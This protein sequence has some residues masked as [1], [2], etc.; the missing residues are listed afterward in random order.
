MGKGDYQMKIKVFTAVLLALVLAGCSA[1][2]TTKDSGTSSQSTSSSQSQSSEAKQATT[3]DIL[4]VKVTVNEAITTYQKTFAQ[5]DI[6]S[7]SLEKVGNQFQY[8]VEGVDDQREHQLT[9]NATTSSVI[10]KHSE[11][12]DADETDGVARHEALKL[13]N[14]ISLSRAVKIAQQSA[15][16]T[17]AT[18]AKLD[19][20]NGQTVWKIQFEQHGQETEVKLNAQTGKV[21]A[22][23]VDD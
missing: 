18:E 11:Q 1:K 10:N 8:E 20:E 2:E 5:T 14:F 6:T 17:G 4:Q 22:T 23:E 21:L 15:E 16:V 12:L 7:I 13:T 3:S 9:L 19:Q